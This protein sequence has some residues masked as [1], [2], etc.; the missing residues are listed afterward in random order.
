MDSGKETERGALDIVNVSVQSSFR[1]VTGVAAATT[2]HGTV[3][4]TPSNVAAT[5]SSVVVSPWC[6]AQ[7][8][9]EI[10]CFV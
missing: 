2:V 9:P 6:F 10:V 8:S 7:Y 3:A 1:V 4:A 5:P